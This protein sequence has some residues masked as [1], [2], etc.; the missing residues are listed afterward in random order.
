MKV[1]SL[2]RYR[3]DDIGSLLRHLLARYEAGELRGLALCAKDITGRE[4]VAFVGQYGEDY[5]SA[6]VAGLRIS[7]LINEMDAYG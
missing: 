3:R 1:V 5:P 2:E 4:D 7:K 6:V